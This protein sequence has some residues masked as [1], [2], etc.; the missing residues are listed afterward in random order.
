MREGQAV[1]QKKTRRRERQALLL[2]CGVRFFM[3]A[4]LT[5]NQI[6]GGY[7][8]FA[9]GSVAASGAGS[10]GFCALLG[11]AAGALALMDFAQALPF[12]ASA[13]LIQ[14]AAAVFRGNRMLSGARS[15]S[16]AAAALFLSVGLVYALDEAGA[17]IVPCLAA[18]GLAG[19]STWF[20]WPLLH[21]EDGRG[22]AEGIVFLAAALL[23]AMQDTAVAGLSLGRMLLCVLLAYTAFTQGAAVGAAAGLCLGLTAD[24]CAGDGSGVLAAGLGMGSLLCGRYGRGRRYLAALCFLGGTVLTLLCGTAP[25]REALAV[26]CGTGMLLFLLLP[27]K[28]FGGQAAGETPPGDAGGEKLKERLKRTA[29]TLREIYENCGEEEAR[30][31]AAGIYERAAE[32]VCRTCVRRDQC[33]KRERVSTLAALEQTLPVLLE[34]GEACAGDFPETFSKRCV[35]FLDFLAALN[36]ELRAFL[37]RRHYR[38][39]VE[40]VRREARG[41]YVQL[42]ELL[43]AAASG[44]GSRNG[45]ARLES[46]SNCR[47]GSAQRPKRGERICGDSLASFRTE[48]GRWCLLLADGMGSGEEARRESSLT[49]RLL[50]EFLEAGIQ[51]EP[52]LQTLNAAM[53]LRGTETGGFATMDLC[54]FDARSGEASFYKY[55]AAPSYL[56]KGGAVR[57][58]TGAGLPVG[59]RGASAAPDMTRVRLEPGSF[60][61]M[62][63]DGVAD[64]GED[65]WLRELLAGW[66]GD[67]PQ[68]LA[69]AILSESV[70]RRNSRDDC[71][72]QILYL[73]PAAAFA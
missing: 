23:L 73:P 19:A 33:W 16:I 35:C 18:A 67:E 36:G 11:A 9:L 17:R 29:S 26:E 12:L 40:E 32:R 70:R 4:A 71:G 37:L 52:A 72:V 27:E 21:P 54:V 28:L 31:N 30:E 13:V 2:G 60:A 58:V 69:G 43:A 8:P 48:E 38:L 15:M 61:V 47:L 49:C 65:E 50:R 20:F 68:E 45:G 41:Q 6:L 34:R 53:S 66:K 64:P 63:S 59:L 46:G 51:P 24:L 55:G 1:K 39:Q 7:A 10:G 44:W 62:I 25:I 14:A 5:G 42:A 57:R 22:S 56:K 3:A